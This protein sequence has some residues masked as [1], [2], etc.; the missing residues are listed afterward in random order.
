MIFVIRN[1]KHTSIVPVCFDLNNVSSEHNTQLFTMQ[2]VAQVYSLHHER[3]QQ[4]DAEHT[5][6]CLKRST[7]IDAALSGGD[8]VAA[9]VPS[10]VR[11]REMCVDM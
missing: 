6:Q 3:Q 11:L 4:A 2:T 10:Q 5:Q 1:G 7:R 8:D 9:R